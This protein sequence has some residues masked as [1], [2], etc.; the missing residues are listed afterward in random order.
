MYSHKDKY[1]GMLVVIGKGVG[2]ARL[3]YKELITF[4]LVNFFF[5][6]NS[7]KG[8]LNICSPLDYCKLYCVHEMFKAMNKSLQTFL[9]PTLIPKTENLAISFCQSTHVRPFTMIVREISIRIFKSS[10]NAQFLLNIV[11]YTKLNLKITLSDIWSFQI[12]GNIMSLKLA[13]L[14]ETSC[15]LTANCLLFNCG[16]PKITFRDYWPLDVYSGTCE[17]KTIILFVAL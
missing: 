7:K 14:D 5:F 6:L 3:L 13:K 11:I 2:K 8:V 17:H 12:T 9:N 10:W 16:A 1:E 15:E 4:Q